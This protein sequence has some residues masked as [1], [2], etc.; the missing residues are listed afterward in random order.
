[1]QFLLRNLALG[2]SLAS[3]ANARIVAATE[4]FKTAEAEDSLFQFRVPL[5]E[6]DDERLMCRIQRGDLEAFEVLFD[7]YSGLLIRVGARLF[8]NATEAEDLVQEVFLYLFRRSH[9]FDSSKGSV[10]SWLIQVTYSRAFNHQKSRNGRSHERESSEET[11]QI[12]PTDPRPDPEELAELASWRSYFLKAFNSLRKEQREA[13]E[14]YFFGG[15]TL[16]EICQKTG[17]SF[18]SVRNHVYRG[19]EQLRIFLSEDGFP[20]RR[21]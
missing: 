11:V 10:R 17:Y 19:L 16:Q 15:Y 3:S 20:I 5:R 18:P 14:M 8:R 7:R 2:G 6:L 13:I 4:T 21:A 12:H 9:I 1:V